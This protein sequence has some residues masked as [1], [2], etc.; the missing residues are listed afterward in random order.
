MGLL[1]QARKN[2]GPT[3]KA[4]RE[5]AGLSHLDVDERTHGQI[6]V[7]LIGQLENGLREP[8]DEQWLLLNRLYGAVLA[9][10]PKDG[11]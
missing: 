9:K 11:A 1:P 3:L 6:S 2:L 5:R 7:A 4:T 8:T 10:L